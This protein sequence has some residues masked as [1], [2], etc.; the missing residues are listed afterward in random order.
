MNVNRLAVIASSIAVAATVA[1]GLY[2]AGSPGEQR[3]YRMDE[4]RVRDLGQI[5][6]AVQTHW[7]RHQEVPALLQEA[8]DGQQLTRL[9]ADPGTESEYQYL[10]AE[11]RFQLCAV[12]DRP[13]PDPKPGDFWAHPEGRHC[14]EFDATRVDA[15]VNLPVGRAVP[16][17]P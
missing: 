7:Q 6:V 1:A 16:V 5:A 2:L 9:P 4:R 14:F 12:F 3:L 17:S 10:P 8:V 11:D 13:S 15:L